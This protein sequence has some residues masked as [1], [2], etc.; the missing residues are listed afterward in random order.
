MLQKQREAE[1]LIR[2][3]EEDERLRIELEEQ[4]AIELH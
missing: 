3:K 4:Q 2:Q 1:A